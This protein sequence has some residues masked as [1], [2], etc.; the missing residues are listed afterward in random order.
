MLQYSIFSDESFF[1]IEN[2]F[3][4]S[5]CTLNPQKNIK[6]YIN[7]TVNEFFFSFRF[8]DLC[9]FFPF[10]HIW[11]VDVYV[12][13]AFEKYKKRV[14]LDLIF[15]LCKSSSIHSFI[16]DVRF[17]FYCV[18]YLI[19]IKSNEMDNVCELLEFFFISF[20]YVYVL[21]FHF[22]RKKNHFI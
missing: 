21:Y 7:W 2:N 15:F 13:N 4:K 12:S 14:L 19:I 1:Y 8:D 9:D 3:N 22:K 5:L 10:I 11:F 17:F 16:L 20:K 6:N 18:K